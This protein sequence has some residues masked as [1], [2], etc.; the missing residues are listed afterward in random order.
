[1]PRLPGS[2]GKI[3]DLRSGLPGNLASTVLPVALGAMQEEEL[4]ASGRF[5]LV[6]SRTSSGWLGRLLS[7]GLQLFKLLL[8]ALKFVREAAGR[9]KPLLFFMAGLALA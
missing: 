4:A 5:F 8:K 3:G 9:V 1:M 6:G 7:L 2:I